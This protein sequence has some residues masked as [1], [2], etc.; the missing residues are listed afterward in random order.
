MRPSHQSP[1]TSRVTFVSWPCC[2][3]AKVTLPLRVSLSV[4]LRRS[5]STVSTSPSSLRR[6][7]VTPSG[8]GFT[9]GGGRVN[10]GSQSVVVPVALKVRSP[11]AKVTPSKEALAPW[12]AM[13]LHTKRSSNSTVAA[14]SV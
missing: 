4:T 12:M 1:G 6:A 7:S 5:K 2:I 13:S 8:Y 11:R 14:S 3:P 10:T 9:S